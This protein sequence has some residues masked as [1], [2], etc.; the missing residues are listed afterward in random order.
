MTEFF[1]GA[2]AAGCLVIALFFLRFWRTTGDRFF[3]LFALAFATFAGNR[4][5]LALL[6]EENEHRTLAY[7]VR[8]LAFV[9][10]L[11]AVID[12]NRR[13]ARASRSVKAR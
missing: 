11:A 1:L 9:I 3:A 7:V 2:T 5:V 10:I 13:P 8:L 12:K 4:F 6:D